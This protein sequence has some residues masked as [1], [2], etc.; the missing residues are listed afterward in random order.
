MLLTGLVACDCGCDCGSATLAARAEKGDAA[1]ADD[2][3][4]DDAAIDAATESDRC[5]E[6][7]DDARLRIAAAW[8]AWAAAA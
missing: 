6:K 8:A 5:R 4:A 7:T 2:A 1:A 3:A